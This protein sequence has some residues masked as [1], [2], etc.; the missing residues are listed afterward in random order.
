MTKSTKL[1]AI[2]P[3]PDHLSTATT[4]RIKRS[5]GE[6]T[7]HRTKEKGEALPITKDWRHG[8]YVPGDGDITYHARAGS[9][10]KHLKSHGN[11]T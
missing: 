4:T 2:R 11:L 7:G 9:C 6:F 3:A 10:H 8:H 1:L 5:H